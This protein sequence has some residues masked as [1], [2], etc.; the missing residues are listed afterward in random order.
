METRL[1]PQRLGALWLAGAALLAFSL[2]AGAQKGRGSKDKKKKGAEPTKIVPWLGDYD[3]ALVAARE[4]N[5][6][7]AVLAILEGEMTSDRVR[8]EI[9][10]GDD[11]NR[12]AA[13]TV[14]LLVNNG[15]H[16]QKTLVEKNAKGEKVERKVCS[17]FEVPTCSDHKRSWKR[18][19]QEH[20]EGEDM[21]VPALIVLMPNGEEHGRS[22][23]EIQTGEAID[24]IRK[25]RALAGPS[26]TKDELLEVKGKL[27]T[28]ESSEKTRFFE[29]AWK[30]YSRVLEITESS[31]WAD[32]ARA[33]RDRAAVAMQ[34]NVDE[35]LAKMEAG[36]VE[37]GYE[38]LL[39]Y[40]VDYAGTPLEKPLKDT[41][42]KVERRKEWKDAI[43]AV[44]HRRDADEIWAK[45]EE[46]LAQGKK[47]VAERHAKRILKKFADTPAA[48]LVRQRFPKL[49]EGDSGR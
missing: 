8:D 1:F 31:V 48:E 35:A 21:V 28:G 7:L 5:A 40:Q 10:K 12:V 11:F 33:G 25:A 34:R 6:P 44:K 47:T 22:Q 45:C 27:D 49:V 15:D 30:A 23:D 38:R 36:S 46:A 19:F 3:G 14:F 13:H 4:R 24:I 9:F 26:L 37:L 42:K 41:L 18:V 17:V 39:Q 20:S 2:T 29:T 43:A 32:R 16:A